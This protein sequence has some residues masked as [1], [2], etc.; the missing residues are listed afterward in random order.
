MNGYKVEFIFHHSNGHNSKSIVGIDKY[1]I[2]SLSTY[3][4]NI[5][6]THILNYW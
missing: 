3:N 5:L 6:I 2:I 1:R 4:K